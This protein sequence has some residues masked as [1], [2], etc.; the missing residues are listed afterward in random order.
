MSGWHAAGA[1]D[2][3][4][5]KEGKEKDQVNAKTEKHV[6]KKGMMSCLVG[7]LLRATLEVRWAREYWHR[8]HHNLVYYLLHM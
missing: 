7:S 1:V 4:R 3:D 2:K 5:R 8:G 6:A